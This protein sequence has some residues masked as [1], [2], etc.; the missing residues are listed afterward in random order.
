M[1]AVHDLYKQLDLAGRRIEDCPVC[2]AKAG[3]W[4]YSTSPNDPRRVTGMC[5]HGDA[6]GPQDGMV[7]EGCLLYM[8]P[9]GFYQPT[10]REAL[11]YWNDYAKA[12]ADLRQDRADLYQLRLFKERDRHDHAG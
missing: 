12:L 11:R 8:P 4:Q 5:S 3:L 6:F 10:E 2:G 7:N 9:E 1:S